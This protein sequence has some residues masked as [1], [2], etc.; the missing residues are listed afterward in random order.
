MITLANADGAYFSD[1]LGTA[2]STL[3]ALPAPLPDDPPVDPASL[4]RFAGTY[5]DPFDA[6]KV[7]VT[8]DGTNLRISIAGYDAAGIK[9]DAVLQPDTDGRN[10]FLGTAEGPDGLTFIPDGTSILG[11]RTRSFFARRTPQ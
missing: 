1:T 8:H 2:L 9:Y 10:F 5:V 3:T 6:G 11:V 4:A 7:T